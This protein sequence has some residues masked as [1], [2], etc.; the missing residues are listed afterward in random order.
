MFSRAI[1]GVFAADLATITISEKTIGVT[2]ADQ[3][4]KSGCRCVGDG[5][6]VV[7]ACSK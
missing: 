5:G 2:R 1:C 6:D 4:T 7:D 3:S